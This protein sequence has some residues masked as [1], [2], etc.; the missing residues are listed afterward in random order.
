MKKIRKV[1]VTMIISFLFL[2]SIATGYLKAEES[3]DIMYVLTAFN[4]ILLGL[5]QMI[6]T[7]FLTDG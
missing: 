4:G 6:L 7:F 1:L 2:G 5:M 3:R